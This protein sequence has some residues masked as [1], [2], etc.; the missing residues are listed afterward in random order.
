MRLASGAQQCKNIVAAEQGERKIKCG[1]KKGPDGA[2]LLKPVVECDVRVMPKEVRVFAIPAGKTDELK[3]KEITI[4][5][6]KEMCKDFFL[7][8]ASTTS[9]YVS[10]NRRC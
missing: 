5:Q 2:H 9:C 3:S 4:G 6:V 8:G 7:P 1:T 10:L